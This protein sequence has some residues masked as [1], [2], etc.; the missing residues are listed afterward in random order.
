VNGKLVA[1][2]TMTFALGPVSSHHP[3]AD[4]GDAESRG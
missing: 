2:G 1:D 3:D 4:G